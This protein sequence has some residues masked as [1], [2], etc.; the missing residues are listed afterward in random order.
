MNLLILFDSDFIDEHRVCLRD[1]RLK[2]V[3][4]VHQAQ[5]GDTLRAGK[6]NGSLGE[7]RIITLSKSELIMDVS[8]HQSPPPPLPLTLIVALPRPKMFRRILRLSAELGIKQL[9][10]IH[11]YR[12]EKSYWQS[13][14]LEESVQQEHFIAGLEQAKDTVLPT[15]HF[16]RFF[17]PFVED[18]LPDISNNSHKLLCHPG[19]A[20]PCPHQHNEAITLIIG[21][22]G[23]FIP[24]EVEKFK[25]ADFTQ[26]HLGSRIYRVEHAIPLAIAKLYD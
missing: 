11:S 9:H 26:V 24:Y 7:G 19:D 22:E 21:P 14:A 4:Q 5:E 3:L 8:L 2:H 6:L 10:F 13:P 17:K 12:V 23:G 20:L 18:Q 25:A 16:H 1:R 15:V